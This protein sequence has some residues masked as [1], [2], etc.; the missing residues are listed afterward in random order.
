M[1]TPIVGCSSL[2]LSSNSLSLSSRS[3]TLKL[4]GGSRQLYFEI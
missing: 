3:A 4:L 1:T 2:G